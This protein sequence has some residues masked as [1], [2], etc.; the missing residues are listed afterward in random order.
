MEVL[1]RYKES[2][3]IKL[4]TISVIGSFNNYDKSE[5]YMKKENVIWYYKI[6]LG[7]GK[8][9][10]KFIIN[11][12]LIINDPEA[13]MYF[14]D[15]NEELWSVIVINDNDERMYNNEEYSVHIDSYMITN[16]IS[17]EEKII[18]KK[19]FS[20]VSDKKIVTRFKFNN[21]T[22]I[23]TVVVAWFTPDDELF[24]YSENNL[25]APNRE[26]EGFMWFWLDLD[27]NKHRLKLGKWKIK[28]F[29]DGEFIL[30]DEIK[31]LNLNT[32]SSMGKI[33]F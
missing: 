30:E 3:Y 25:F 27:D 1:I 17:E 21:V 8:H 19:V 11:D 31:I 23:H 14:P 29:I 4:Q 12:E 16:Y 9:Y 32:Y 20:I 13:N 28:M 2:E 26:H 6:N 15:E 7:P 10:Y 5:G 22:G 18:N 24:Q 33:N